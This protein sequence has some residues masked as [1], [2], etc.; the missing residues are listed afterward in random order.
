MVDVGE[1]LP[2][3]LAF[4]QD[5]I[6][7]IVRIRRRELARV[8]VDADRRVARRRHRRIALAIDERTQDGGL[9]PVDQPAVGDRQDGFAFLAQ[10]ADAEDQIFQRIERLLLAIPENHLLRDALIVL[11]P[12]L[13]GISVGVLLL[14]RIDTRVRR[15]K[16]TSASFIGGTMIPT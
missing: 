5:R 3:E 13:R 7:E 12:R 15:A 14:D 11:L 1:R 4:A 9:V 10:V 16:V 6:A 8:G 2:V